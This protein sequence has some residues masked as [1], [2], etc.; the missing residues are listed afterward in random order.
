MTDRDHAATQRDLPAA[1][2]FDM[3]G[4]L[5]D[6]EPYWI[7]EETALVE[8]YGGTWNDD[9]AHRLVGQALTWSADF[10]RAN[11]PVTMPRDEIVQHLMGGV[12]RRFREHVPWR[13]GAQDLLTQTRE[14]GVPRALV[15]M[16][17]EAFAA[18]LVAALPEGTFDVVVTGDMV[19]EGK[20][21]PEAYLTA[22][23]HL[24]VDPA[25]CLAIEDSNTGIASALA[26]G[27]PTIG[28]PHIVP[29]PEQEGLRLV[30]TMQGQ[31]VAAL[32]R[33]FR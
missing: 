11:S 25:R 15:T 30:P 20:P 19:V 14:L 18:E 21:H 33:L 22:A 16:S 4:T 2:L 17:Y 10:I 31:S 6:S 13:P 23:E 27:V 32:W 8:S 9:L 28:I 3:D 26:A 24:G 12:I 5:V 1:V 29:I 7:I